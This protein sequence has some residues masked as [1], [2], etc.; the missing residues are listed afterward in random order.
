M[1]KRRSAGVVTLLLHS[2]IFEKFLLEKILESFPDHNEL[3]LD[4]VNSL[5]DENS[6]ILSKILDDESI[7]LF[8]ELLMAV[9][10]QFL[11]KEVKIEKSNVHKIINNIKKE[12]NVS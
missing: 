2:K 7:I 11:T 4:F 12:K 10:E 1:R 3:I 9:K 6:T 8:E 5:V